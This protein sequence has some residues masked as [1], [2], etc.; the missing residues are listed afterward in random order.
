MSRRSL[1]SA[2]A[3]ATISGPMPAASP[4]VIAMRGLEI[5]SRLPFHPFHLGFA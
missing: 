1:K 2:K 3:R 4:S 5:I